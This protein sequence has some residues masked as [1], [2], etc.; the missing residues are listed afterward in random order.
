MTTSASLQDGGVVPAARTSWPATVAWVVL[1][2]AVLAVPLLGEPYYTKL[3]ARFAIFAIV[4]VGLDLVV[5]YA[6]LMSLGQ[7]AFFGI[8]V[9]AT[10]W[11]AQSGVQQAWVVVPTSMLVAASCALLTGSVALRARGLN[12]IFITLAF[13]QMFFFLASGLQ[14]FGGDDG[15]RLPLPTL[16]VGSLRL[17]DPV[18]LAYSCLAVLLLVTLGARRLMRS[19]F[20]RVVIGARDNEQ[21]L[22]AVGLP[23]YPYHLALYAV[24]AAL[25]A[26][27]GVLYANL[28]EFVSPSTLSWTLSGEFLFMVILG[29]AATLIGPVLGAL[30]FVGLELV[31]SSWTEHWALPLGLLLVARVLFLD[32]GLIGLLRRRGE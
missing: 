24:A 25:A 12:F 32:R 29:G 7:A 17:T 22:A 11:L 20:G 6:G 26:V 3:V 18:L 15:V 27:G 8:G 19:H 30:V 16:L 21:R 4:A 5:G 10:G 28:T 1:A 31:L 14:R 2:A 13:A 9:Y 23:A